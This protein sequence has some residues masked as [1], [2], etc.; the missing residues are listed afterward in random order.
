MKRFNQTYIFALAF[1]LFFASCD[2]T[3]DFVGGS[4]DDGGSDVL[5]P[6]EQAELLLNSIEEDGGIPFD[7]DNPALSFTDAQNVF[8]PSV[9]GID[10]RVD[11]SVVPAGP[12]ARFPM[13]QGWETLPNGTQREGYYV[14]TEA[15]DATLARE[16]GIIFSP[17]MA[18]AI[19]SG[20]EQNSQW[21]ED[22]RLIF[23]GSVDF[24]PTRNL[25]A[26]GASEDGLLVGFPPAVV[27]P[28]AIADDN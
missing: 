28:G 2:R 5:S 6:V 15:S 27:E 3:D 16:L 13:F 1:S 19:G 20:G 10:F 12:T 24:S 21:T 26:G 17:R 23:E 8:L 25:V 9:L 7:V 4:D 22:G 18:N 11:R 14:I